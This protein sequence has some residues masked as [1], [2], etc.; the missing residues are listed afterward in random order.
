V[1]PRGRDIHSHWQD[2]LG[3]VWANGHI[4]AERQGARHWR[5]DDSSGT[6]TV[7][8][9]AELYQWTQWPAPGTQPSVRH[10]YCPVVQA[11]LFMPPA[12]LGSPSETAIPIMLHGSCI[13]FMHLMKSLM[14][15][16]HALVAL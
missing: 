9:S 4:V 16:V 8:A 13:K 1:G 11:E 7:L 5:D 2:A 14:T 6:V 15:H 3:K 12:Q 10:S